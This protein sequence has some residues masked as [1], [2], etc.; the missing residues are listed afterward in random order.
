MI[1]AQSLSLVFAKPF[2]WRYELVVAAGIGLLLLLSGS[3]V[4]SDDKPGDK[5]D[6]EDE[7]TPLISRAGRFSSRPVGEKA[8]RLYLKAMT[9]FCLFQRFSRLIRRSSGDVSIVVS[10]YLDRADRIRSQYWSSSWSSLLNRSLVFLQVSQFPFQ[11]EGLSLDASSCSHQPVMYFSTRIFAPI[12]QANSKLVA[13]GIMI[14]GIPFNF[15]PG[16]LPTVR[17]YLL[18]TFVFPYLAHPFLSVDWVQA[19][20]PLLISR[21]SYFLSTIDHRSQCTSPDPFM[22]RCHHIRHQL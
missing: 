8:D 19:H 15:V 13:L 14:I 1:F 3:L 7:E 22:H 21:H 4:R 9:R 10:Q 17:H 20:A 18:E 16:L 11:S 2:E 5:A 12:F 6:G